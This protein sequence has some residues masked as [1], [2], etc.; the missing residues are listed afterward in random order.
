ML[1]RRIC[2]ENGTEV[3]AFVTANA[4]D[5]RL[6]SLLQSYYLVE[7]TWSMD[8]ASFTRRNHEWGPLI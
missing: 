3:R 1:A 7:H 5:E 6:A 8:L 2:R 4:L